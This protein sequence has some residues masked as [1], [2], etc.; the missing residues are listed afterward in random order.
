M[1]YILSLINIAYA[2]NTMVLA[3]LI[4]ENES[5]SPGTAAVIKYHSIRVYTYARDKCVTPGCVSTAYASAKSFFC[6]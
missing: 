5:I 3:Q 1:N 4:W 6:G 2:T